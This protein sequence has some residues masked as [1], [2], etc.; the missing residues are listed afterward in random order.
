MDD[1]KYLTV[2]EAAA[3][4]RTH[5]ETIRRWLR[6]GLLPHARKT[7]SGYSWLIPTSDLLAAPPAEHKD[8]AQ[9]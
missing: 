6:A 4:M 8:G 7:P 9:R 1:D 5:P 2:T 3:V